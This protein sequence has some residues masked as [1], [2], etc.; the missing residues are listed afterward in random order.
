[1]NILRRG[2][3]QVPHPHDEAEGH[4]VPDSKD[5]P[6]PMPWDEQDIEKEKKC[7][8]EPKHRPND[9]SG[10]MDWKAAERR[11]RRRERSH[12]TLLNLANR[13]AIILSR[14]RSG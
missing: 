12:G 2:I 11:W 6:E 10:G 5:A 4:Q 14:A 7:T 3:V 8:S 9:Q 1:M 13:R